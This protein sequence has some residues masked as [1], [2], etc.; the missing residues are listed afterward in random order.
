[1]TMTRRALLSAVAAG[2][3]FGPALAASSAGVWP[4]RPVR[5]IS[6]YAAGGSSDISLRILAEHFEG[7]MGQNFFVENKPGA[8]STIANQT[9]ARADPDGYTFL[10]AAAP[11]ETAEAMLGKLNYDPHKDLRPIAMS[12]FVPLFLIVNANA[13]YKTLPEFIAYAKSKPDGVT[14]ATPTAGSQP[15]LAAELLIRTAGIKGVSVQFRGDAPSYIELLAGR[16]DATTTALPAALPHIQSGALRV[17]GCFSDARSSVYPDAKTLREQGTD[18]TSVGWYGFMAPAATPDPIIERMQS[19]IDQALADP[20]IKQKLA[21]QGLDVHY[22]PGPEFGKFI[23]S[24][25]E[26]WSKIIREAGIN[27][28]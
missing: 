4:A 8:G 5:L 14:F 17:L 11:Y 6:T 1:M 20:V 2:M 9:A 13:P 16:V 15:H 24:E 19:E 26:K 10:Y 28:P 25:T 21:V 7:R 18:V 23:D 12:M 22:L 3:T 27:K